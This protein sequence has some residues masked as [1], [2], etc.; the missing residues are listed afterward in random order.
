[1]KP[2]KIELDGKVYEIDLS[3]ITKEQ[4]EEMEEL[5]KQTAK[6]IYIGDIDSAHKSAYRLLE[7]ATGIEEEKLSKLDVVNIFKIF[8]FVKEG[9]DEIITYGTSNLLAL[10]SNNEPYPFIRLLVEYK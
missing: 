10:H 3:K 7:L 8:I 1:M 2:I 6:N 4:L 9:I 5:R